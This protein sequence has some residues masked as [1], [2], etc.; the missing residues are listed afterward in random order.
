MRASASNR[1]P[2]RSLRMKNLRMKKTVIETARKNIFSS[3][4]S[5]GATPLT[6]QPLWGYHLF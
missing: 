4:R 3:P 1:L 5:L 2:I 6:T